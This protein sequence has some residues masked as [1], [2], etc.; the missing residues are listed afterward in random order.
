MDPDAVFSSNG[1][2]TVPPGNYFLLGDNRNDS[3]DSR[4]WGFVPR[5]AIEGEPL[6][7][8]FSLREPDAGESLPSRSP[9]GGISPQQS[10]SWGAYSPT[11]FD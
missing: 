4:Y 8:Y 1:E 9:C 3:Q 6:L 11:S 10:S 7:V 5:A 2:L